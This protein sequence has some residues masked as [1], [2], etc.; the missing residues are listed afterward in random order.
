MKHWLRFNAVGA[1][2]VVVQLAIL[3]VLRDGCGLP[4]LVATALAVEAALLH[5]FYWHQRWTWRDRP[6]VPGRLGRFHIS[7]GV[8]SLLGNLVLMRLLV[9]EAGLHY[10]AANVTTISICAAANFLTADRLVFRRES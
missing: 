1:A 5:N 6:P 3:A 2:G 10:L 7:N 9:G 4:Y 8:V